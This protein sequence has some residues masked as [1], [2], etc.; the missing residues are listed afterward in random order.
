M[1]EKSKT[2]AHQDRQPEG[3][4]DGK[5]LREDYLPKHSQR[6]VAVISW[7]FFVLCGSI[8]L[9]TLLPASP[10]HDVNRGIASLSGF[11]FAALSLVFLHK[12]KIHLAVF[13]IG[14]LIL[15]ALLVYQIRVG[16]GVRSPANNIALLLV[17]MA[18]L[19]LGRGPA[20]LALVLSVSW[21]FAVTVA[22]LVGWIPGFTAH[23][24][25]LLIPSAIINAGICLS[26]YMLIER[27][28]V[29]VQNAVNDMNAEQNA[30]HRAESEVQQTQMLVQY[31]DE[32]MAMLSHEIRTPLNGVASGVQL[33]FHPK[34]TE[35]KK[36]RAR[37]AIV[38]SLSNVSEVLNNLLDN[39]KIDAGKLELKLEPTRLSE[40]MSG[41]E[42][43]YAL[44]AESKGLTL[45]CDCINTPP[46]PLELD[47]PRLRQMLNN[48]V[49]NAVKFTPSGSIRV[50]VQGEASGPAAGTGE[51]LLR[52][53]V[54][55][56]G[57]GISE[58][59]QATLFTEYVQLRNSGKQQSGTGLG[60]VVVKKLAQL[61]GGD[62]GVWSTRGEG[63]TFWFTVRTRT[64][65]TAPGSDEAV[66]A[67]IVTKQT[68]E[69]EA[70]PVPPAHASGSVN[71][72]TGSGKE[73][74]KAEPGKAEPVKILPDA[75]LASPSALPGSSNNA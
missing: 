21:I 28:L 14:A 59:D 18:G 42:N 35:E 52:F 57:C 61:M 70:R 68:P 2:E 6:S 73:P 74:G 64:V 27:Y 12:K 44:Q 38:Q 69:A 7:F 4:N 16:S 23:N 45:S 13:S 47:A 33:L 19:L 58:A 50:E 66:Y 5:L 63:A 29:A 65:Q 49:S 48:L 3:Q 41:I 24:A 25:P 10:G 39:S 67:S 56:S 1:T 34:A 26:L 72:Q 46:E 60:L 36:T 8:A 20:R 32:F 17:P 71:A 37:N 40:L 22:E 43:A 54:I 55:D 15:V 51:A 53:K 30:R 9:F 11:G 75:T 31:K 62:A